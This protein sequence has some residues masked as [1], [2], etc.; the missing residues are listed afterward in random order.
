[1]NCHIQIHHPPDGTVSIRGEEQTVRRIARLLPQHGTA[2]LQMVEHSPFEA[3][4]EVDFAAQALNRMANGRL[5][6]KP[7]VLAQLTECLE[8]AVKAI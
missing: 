8:K 4:T 3:R 2:E 6:T 5:P 1:M 7:H